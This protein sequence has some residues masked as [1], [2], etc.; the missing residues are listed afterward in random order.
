MAYVNQKVFYPYVFHSLS[1]GNKALLNQYV[2]HYVK[3][4]EPGY[5]PMPNLGYTDDYIVCV[6]IPDKL[7]EIE[8]RKKERWTKKKK[9]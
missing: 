2:Q 4:T 9:K 5:R 1:N 3:A 7:R 6:P 8:E